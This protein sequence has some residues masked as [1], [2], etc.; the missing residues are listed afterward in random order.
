MISNELANKNLE[1]KLLHI[2]N[3]S[4]LKKITR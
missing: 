1:K 3:G 4:L 2:A